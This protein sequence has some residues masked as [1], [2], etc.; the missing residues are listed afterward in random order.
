MAMQRFHDPVSM[1]ALL[2]EAY[3]EVVFPATPDREI[4]DLR[5]RKVKRVMYLLKEA[6]AQN[7]E[8][9][10]I[11]LLS[12][13][14][15][16]GNHQIASMLIENPDCDLNL[17][18]EHGKT[19]LMQAVESNHPDLISQFI[20]SERC[21]LDR[22]DNDGETALFHAVYKNHQK[23]AELLMVARCDV[24]LFFGEAPGMTLLDWAF[25]KNNLYMVH[26]LL[27]HGAKIHNANEFFDTL[28]KYDRRNPDLLFC[29]SIL[30]RQQKELRE[31]KFA[32]EQRCLL[33]E[34]RFVQ[35]QNYLSKLTWIKLSVFNEIA[36]GTQLP[37]DPLDVIAEYDEPLKRFSHQKVDSII[38]ADETPSFKP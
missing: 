29:L 18:N 9:I 37:K 10:L 28:I 21:H 34:E 32:G 8:Q 24:N 13:S 1:Q 38:F 35:A 11:V 36:D 25:I 23:I 4:A 6:R 31:S 26:S 30:C 20:K 3:I 5:M 33:N 17:Q 14:I 7:Y 19:V 22:K 12:R 2:E 16:G 27:K 15:E